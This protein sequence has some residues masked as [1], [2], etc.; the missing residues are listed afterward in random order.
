MA[1]PERKESEE[2]LVVKMNE[3]LN[4]SKD[5]RDKI[6][7]MPDNIL[8]HM[9]NFMDTREAVQ[10]CVLSKRWNNLWKRLTSLL[11]NSSKFGSVVKIINFL[12]MFLS[13]RDDSISLSTVYLDLSQRPR[14]STSCLGFLIT[15]AYDW[16][17]LNRLMKYAVSHNCQRLSIK[18]L[19][20]CKFEVDPVIFSC[21]SLISLRLS[22]TPFGTNCKLPKS[23][24]LPVLKTLYL[25]HVCFTA[26]DNGCAELFSTCFLLNTLVLERCSLDQYAEV[27]C[28]SNSNLSCLILDNA[29]EDADTIVLSTPKLSLLTIKDDF[30][31]NKYSSTCNLSFLEKVY[32]DASG[33]NEDSSEHLSWL[34]LV[35]NIKEMILSADTISFIRKGLEVLD[36]V[37][38]QPPGFVNLESLVVKRDSFDFISDEEVNCV[39][40]FLLQNSIQTLDEEKTVNITYTNSLFKY[41]G[42]TV[43]EYDN[44]ETLTNL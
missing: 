27:I 6:S 9:M 35:T 39:V 32:V 28:I 20:Y 37:R 12:Y 8:L 11:F 1:S 34:Q 24:Q 44:L 25:H 38:I 2:K 30:C 10:T 36:S 19:F 16:E 41:L 42:K 15:H 18:I 33:Y 29:M 13:D 14:D 40:R 17:C 4:L 21:P 7:E 22:F 3:G 43:L 23:L 5:D 26:S 31:R